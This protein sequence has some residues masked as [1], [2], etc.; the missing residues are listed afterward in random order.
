MHPEMK[1]LLATLQA[2]EMY[3]KTGHWQVKN[4][5]YY[6]DHLL[7]DRLSE[8]AGQRIDQVA[9]KAIGIDNDVTVVNLPEILKKVFEKTRTLPYAPSENV[10][11]FE[12]ALTIEKQLIALC[13]AVE[14]KSSVGV[15]NMLG[16]ICDEA[17]SRIYL[18]QQRVSKKSN[19]TPMDIPQ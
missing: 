16:D 2:L 5:I 15:K 8:E 18:I 13:T 4:T 9:E 14:A 3:Y 7:L 19:P 11:F 17:E 6:S 1:E 12:A 10:K